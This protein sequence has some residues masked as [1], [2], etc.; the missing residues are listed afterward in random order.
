MKYK[1]QYPHISNALSKACGK[2]IVVDEYRSKLV[3]VDD[4]PI[5]VNIKRVLTPY[6]SILGQIER[7]GT[8]GEPYSHPELFTAGVY[9]L[10]AY[11]DHISPC[12]YLRNKNTQMEIYMFHFDKEWVVFC[13][14]RVGVGVSED[15]LRKELQ[16]FLKSYEE[17]SK[18]IL[19]ELK[20]VIKKRKLAAVI[21]FASKECGTEK[22]DDKAL[23]GLVKRYADLCPAATAKD[24]ELTTNLDKAFHVVRYEMLRN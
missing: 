10:R 12:V 24:C 1:N 20:G 16:A 4:D 6:F 23:K 3:L 8:Y 17:Y 15:V 14:L 5:C 11:A 18:I 2:T 22:L 19:T 7:V 13:E 21:E 9:E